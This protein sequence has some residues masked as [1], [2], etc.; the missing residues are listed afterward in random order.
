MID[1]SITLQILNENDKKKSQFCEYKT[2]LCAVSVLFIVHT[3]C[4]AEKK[5]ERHRKRENEIEFGI[6][7]VHIGNSS[8]SSSSNTLLQ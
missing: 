4:E 2:I 5:E 1:E 3:L 6:R 7:F 8:S